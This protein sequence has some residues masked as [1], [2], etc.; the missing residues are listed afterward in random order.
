M[1]SSLLSHVIECVYLHL[2]HCTYVCIHALF[3]VNIHMG[4]TTNVMHILRL[5]NKYRYWWEHQCQCRQTLDLGLKL[6]IVKFQQS[7]PIWIQLRRFYVVHVPTI[8]HCNWYSLA[9]DLTSMH[10][11]REN[12]ACDFLWSLIIDLRVSVI[13][14][15]NKRDEL[16]QCQS[17]CEYCMG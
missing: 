9:R 8:H 12:V 11:T 10:R 7:C 14:V 6:E 16:F 1:F 2:W 13:W 3:F 17:I 4:L 5:S 15:P